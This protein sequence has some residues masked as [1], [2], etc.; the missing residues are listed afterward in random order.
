M[1]LT[2][3]AARAE[4][5][6]IR[7]LPNE[8]LTAVMLEVAIPDLVSLC[9]TSRLIRNIVTPL[10]Y[11]DILLSEVP[12]TKSFLRTM[13]QRSGSLCRYVRRFGI[14]DVTSV[15]EPDAE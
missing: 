12:E 14:V 13:K 1:V 4:K 2:R 5:S 7:W 11:R 6:I 9:M 8:I 10:L 15:T 3:R